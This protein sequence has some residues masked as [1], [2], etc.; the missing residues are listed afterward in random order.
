LNNS[1]LGNNCTGNYG[2]FLNAGSLNNTMAGNICTMCSTMGIDITASNN[3]NTV[4]GNTCNNCTNNCGINLAS[5]NNTVAGNNCTG[6]SVGILVVGNYNNVT[7]NNCTA[8]TSCGIEVES[9]LNNSISWNTCTGRSGGYGIELYGAVNNTLIGNNC[10]GDPIDGILV[11]ASSQNNTIVY[12]N[13]TGNS[14]CGILLSGVYSNNVIGNTFFSNYLGFGIDST[15]SSAYN[16]VTQ[17]R[18][19]KNVENPPISDNSSGPNFIYGNFFLVVPTANFTASATTI[20]VGQ[21]VTFTD[22]TTGGDAPLAYQWNFGDGTGNS[23]Q[24]DIS[25]QFNSAGSWVVVLKVTD[26]DGD[27]SVCSM[28]IHVQGSTTTGSPTNFPTS[29]N[30]SIQVVPPG[31]NP[32]SCTAGGKTLATLTINASSSLSVNMTFRQVNPTPASLPNAVGFLVIIINDT[33]SI[34]F[35][36]TITVYYNASELAAEGISPAS[37]VLWY[38]N[39]ATSTWESLSGTVNI[40]DQSV[41]MQLTHFSTYAIA[42][43]PLDFHALGL[44]LGICAVGVI[45]A[46]A[47]VSYRY[48]GRS[49]VRCL[50]EKLK[51]KRNPRSVNVTPPL[52]A[53]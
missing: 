33:S 8:F 10:S 44:I 46:A 18:F 13:C 39:P 17:N 47:F 16:L 34:T 11:E 53:K 31:N 41:T 50:V 20:Q 27:A 24:Q 12:N 23:T 32:I 5:V 6:D 42:P 29:T 19:K 22:A 38:Y 14:A 3:N 48:P 15:S 30:G 52:P 36:V 35:P 49:P 25:H 40:A 9:A 1:I 45:G 7:S 26:V 4:V 43:A 2:I 51:R 28:A 21:N 37:L